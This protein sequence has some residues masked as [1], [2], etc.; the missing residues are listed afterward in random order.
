M[1]ALSTPAF[2]VD[3]GGVLVFYNE[4]AGTLLGKGFEEV[5][6]RRRRRVGRAL[7]ALRRER[8][9]D[10]L[11]RA[12]A[13]HRGPQR[14]SRPRRTSASARPTAPATTVEVSAFPILTAHGSQ[15]GDRDLLAGRDKR[16]RGAA[17]RE[18]RAL[19]RAR[20]D[21]LPG[22]GDDP[23]RRQHLLRRR[24]PLRRLAA[25]ARR[26]HRHPQPRPRPR[27]TSR[28]AS[29]SSS[30]T[31]T[32]TTSRASP[33]SPRSS[34]P[35]AEIVIWGPASPEASLR[36]RIARYISAPLSPVEVR[37]LPCDVSFRACPER[38]GDRLGPDHRRLG[39]PPRPDA[40]LPDRGRRLLA[41]LHP[42]PRARASAPTSTRLEAEWIS[43]FALAADADLLIHDGQ[44]AD[45]EYPDHLG[46]G[47]SAL[48]H[49]LAFARR[50]GG[51]AHAP[52]PPRPAALRRLARRHGAEARRRG[53]RG[54]AP[55][56]GRAG[57]PRGRVRGRPRGRRV[58]LAPAGRRL[59]RASSIRSAAPI[60]A[61]AARSEL[62]ARALGN[63]R[64]R[65]TPARSA[66]AAAAS[67]T[68]S[69]RDGSPPHSPPTAT[70]TRPSPR[71][72]STTWSRTPTPRS[73]SCAPSSAT[74]SP[75]WSPR[76]PTT[77]R[78]RTTAS[79]RR[80]TAAGSP[81]VDGDAFAIYA[82]D[83]LTNLT[84]LHE[85]IRRE[86]E[87]GRRRV[88]GAAGAEARG[89]GGRRGDAAARGARAAAARPA[90]RRRSA[91]LGR[92]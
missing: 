77:N 41:R 30:P 49:S 87:A 27:P 58:A 8:Q 63:G 85:A 55:G 46:W 1:S 61:A 26:R 18:G 66:T 7:R 40:R 76:S 75:T 71:R 79:A 4:A 51:A 9:A 2:L 29:T 43:G 14:P 81:T 17:R 50:T 45:E 34:A 24:H 16:Q 22:P 72:S 19:G 73:R 88:Q 38:V 80:S 32:S 37:E 44:Y 86:G 83:K 20:V 28:P 52:L 5:G 67:P 47:H 23:L 21:P 42:R 6:T 90:R 70:P 92:I 36:D 65:R 11:R 13:G 89:L 68:S 3:E 33:S 35:Q 25:G 91:F 74:R 59:P 78:S 84:T 57:A 10:P 54:A 56:G 48:S 82:A 53:R 64:P 62:I 69:T 31:S 60:D 12:A 39:R 15:G